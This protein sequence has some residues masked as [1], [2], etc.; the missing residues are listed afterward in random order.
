MAYKQGFRWRSV[1]QTIPLTTTALATPWTRS[2]IFETVAS[3]PYTPTGSGLDPAVWTA[4]T[5]PTALPWGTAA[6]P[7]LPTTVP[8]TY[9]RFEPKLDLRKTRNPPSRSTS[10]TTPAPPSTSTV[11]PVPSTPVVPRL[12]V[13]PVRLTG[14]PGGSRDGVDTVS[15]DINN[16]HSF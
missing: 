10:T 13:A 11:T 1:S 3:D 14:V 4:P 5:P 8:R 9:W 12:T 6:V 16:F 15:D 2:P 7:A